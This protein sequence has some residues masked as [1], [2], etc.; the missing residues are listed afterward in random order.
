[1]MFLAAIFSMWVMGAALLV[2]AATKAKYVFS[3]IEFVFMSFFAGMALASF[4]LLFY[5]S[6]GLRFD[7]LN[8]MAIPTLFFVITISRYMAKPYR[9]GDIL[10]SDNS[11][12]KK[13][14]MEK[15]LFI[16]I[17]IQ[18]LR[19]FLMTL[20]API[21]S[22]DAVANYALKAKIFFLS[23]GIPEGFFAWSESTV[24]HPDY[25]LFLPFVMTWVYVFTSF[26]DVLVRLIMP[27]MYV[28]FIAVFFSMMKKLFD[29][30]YA[31]IAAFI[32]AT[33][34][35]L[36]DYAVII[37]ADLALTAFVAIAVLYLM[38]YIRT[39]NGFELLLAGFMMGSSLWIKNEAMVFTAAFSAVLILFLF[40][41]SGEDKKRVTRDIFRCLALIIAIALP[42]FIVR[43]S[44]GVHNSDLDIG[45][46]TALRVW[47]NIKE[48]PAFF[49]LFQQEV[50]G[51][52][53]WNIFW[54]IF[55]TALIWKRKKLLKGEVLYLTVF[56]GLSALAYFAGYMSMTGE[57]LYFYINTTISR[58]MLHFSGVC[59]ILMGYL[60]YDEVSKA[61][62][63]KPDDKYVFI[64]RDGVINQD[65]AGWTEY[66]YVTKWDDF[67][68]LPGV[69]E[70]FRKLK[71]AGY[72]SI[73]I[74]NQKC[75]GKGIMT[76]EELEKL[77]QEIKNSVRSGGGE[78]SG[79][80]YCTHLDTDNCSCRKPKEGLFLE[81]RSKFGIDTFKGKYF[82]GDSE[83][84]IVAGS[85][86][87][88]GTILVLSGKS[89]RADAAL[90]KIK[91][92]LIAQDFREAVKIVLEG[93]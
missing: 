29:P 79:V 18:A 27:M 5:G 75:V 33:V 14:F 47:E 67:R 76:D 46:L 50:F 92:D 56:L 25:P 87:G 1:M 4:M 82:I 39:G 31:L 57:N 84:D 91:P 93:R 51:P 48:L 2:F 36:A 41:T 21:H 34:P 62:G 71:E 73:V 85:R 65:G 24:A 26:N 3:F 45:S 64:D 53:K 15:L 88:L 16:G 81:A 23:S 69:I 11:G 12:H 52:K 44:S 68:F 10:R 54:I 49:N 61:R 35:Q 59:A 80:F 63:G 30:F 60:L 20:P 9:V 66:G 86:V 55:F 78:I 7:I 19:V 70:G 22:H 89:K 43:A 90:W 37:H 74:S 40:K 13:S 17:A 28:G 38:R 77:T 42:W 6:I 83:R 8:F 58:F 72:K 32:L